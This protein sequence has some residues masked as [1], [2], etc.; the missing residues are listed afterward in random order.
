M[1]KFF[2]FF[3]IVPLIHFSIGVAGAVPLTY[4]EIIDDID[5]S[6]FIGTKG[7]FFDIASNLQ[8]TRIFGNGNNLFTDVDA[9]IV[10]QNN[11]SP[12]FGISTTQNIS[13]S[14]QFVDIPPSLQILSMRVMISAF[15]VSGTPTDFFEFIF[16][17]GIIPNDPIVAE[18]FPITFLTPGGPAFETTTTFQTGQQAI[19][20]SSLDDDFFLDLTVTPTGPGAFFTPDTIAVRTSRFD[21]LYEPIPEPSTIMLFSSG[22]IGLAGFRRKLKKS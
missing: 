11:L 16:G 6:G 18:T 1:R 2:I 10:N 17:T 21:V 9:T 20:S 22:L 13:Y 8:R 7:I 3:F 5:D 12:N 4:T 15:S 14:H 19:I